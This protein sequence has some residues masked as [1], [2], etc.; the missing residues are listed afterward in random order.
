MWSGG[1]HS[2][3]GCVPVGAQKQDLVAGVYKPQQSGN[4]P[5]EICAGLLIEIRAV[6]STHL[7]GSA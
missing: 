4:S 1:Q 7:A 3:A 6:S 2:F 5:E